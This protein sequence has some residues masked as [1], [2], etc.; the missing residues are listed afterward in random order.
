MG[1]SG[2]DGDV[3]RFTNPSTISRLLILNMAYFGIVC[4]PRVKRTW[5]EDDC[6]VSEPGGKGRE[7]RHFRSFAEFVRVVKQNRHLRGED[8]TII[9]SGG[10]TYV[11]PP[12]SSH[13]IIQLSP[14]TTAW[15]S[16]CGEIID[17]I[18][19]LSRLEF[20]LNATSEYVV[21]KDNQDQ[22]A[23]P[24]SSSSS[25]SRQHQIKISKV[26][27]SSSSIKQRIQN[28]LPHMQKWSILYNYML[29]VVKSE[30]LVTYPSISQWY[31]DEDRDVEEEKEVTIRR[32]TMNGGG[33]GQ[34]QEEEEEV[35]EMTPAEQL[36]DDRERLEKRLAG[37]HLDIISF[38]IDTSGDSGN[39]GDLL[40]HREAKIRHH[41]GGRPKTCP[42][43]PQLGDDIV[44]TC[45]E[46]KI[47]KHLLRRKKDEGHNNDGSHNNDDDDGVIDAEN[48]TVDYSFFVSDD[49]AL[50]LTHLWV[51]KN[52][53]IIVAKNAFDWCSAY[54]IKNMKNNSSDTEDSLPMLSIEDALALF[55]S[56]SQISALIDTWS[57][58]LGELIKFKRK[59]TA[60]M[61]DLLANIYK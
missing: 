53:D 11:M 2:N 42:V 47:P 22:H 56:S 7:K 17:F 13:D 16:I 49:L 43:S 32:A 9:V 31:T 45:V 5:V 52:I 4:H 61:G 27:S 38:V 18:R 30:S 50:L 44:L 41:F 15:F 54:V 12:F 19:Q 55:D 46:C 48:Y 36:A 6:H 39:G 26:D 25:V 58:A 14:L 60:H 28:S 59:I 10:P 8:E 57:S 37:S 29:H 34:D 23:Q 35:I 1:D 51:C 3:G 24:S 20:I 21:T 33:G 40:F